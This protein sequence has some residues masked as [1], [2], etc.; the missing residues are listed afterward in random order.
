MSKDTVEIP[1]ELAG[2]EDSYQRA[3]ATIVGMV[4][5]ASELAA[6]K[7]RRCETC[8]HWLQETDPPTTSKIAMRCHNPVG[9]RGATENDFCSHWK[10]RQT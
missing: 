3:L 5:M 10:E 9:L 1:A 2:A 4:G 8:A 7:S 6:L